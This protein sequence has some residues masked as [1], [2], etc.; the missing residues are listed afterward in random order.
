MKNKILLY[1]STTTFDQVMLAL[2]NTG[3]GFL[4]LVDEAGV[5]QGIVTDGDVRKAFLKKTY[6]L[7]SIINKTPVTALFGTP[8]ASI[9]S[10]L[11]KIH[12]NH[13]PVVDESGVL[14]DIVVLNDFAVSSR[15]NWV[16]IMAGGVGSRLG[17]LTKH[18]PKPMLELGGKPMLL[19]IIEN[20][21]RLGFRNFIL[22]IN[23]KAEVI[24][25]YFKDGSRF[26]VNIEY[27]HEKMRLGTAGALSLIQREIKHP[28][29]VVNGDVISSTD[30]VDFLDFHENSKSQATMCIKSY[31][32]SVPFACVEFNDNDELLELRE[33][34]IRNYHINTGMYILNPEVINRVPK[35]EFFDM[36]TLFKQMV[37]DGSRIKV[38][39]MDEYWIDVG[40]PDDYAR[41]QKDIH[42]MSFVRKKL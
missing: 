37:Q 32:Q 16:V 8:N 5:L 12:R 21:E 36:P 11:L 22:C 33:K 31:N 17:D 19:H 24:K 7:D 9:K 18:V 25:R 38:F 2:D 23:Y 20:F 29:F 13:M 27:T 40:R 39:R 34:P 30:F 42:Q 6:T 41:S 26:G 4:A 28:F 1:N 14:K 3:I 15:P 35:D 10:E